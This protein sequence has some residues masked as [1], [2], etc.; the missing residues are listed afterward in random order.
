MNSIHTAE[1][2]LL[3]DDDAGNNMIN[4]MTLKRMLPA[5]PVISFTDPVKGVAYIE[6][7]YGLAPVPAVLLLD[8]NMPVLMGWDV[9]ELLELLPGAVKDSLHVYIASS[10][11]DPEDKNRALSSPLVKGYVE[12]PLSIQTLKALFPEATT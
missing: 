5:V 2:I 1:R 6:K 4:N 8:I 12:K 3:I 9:L 10:S 11:I 7:E